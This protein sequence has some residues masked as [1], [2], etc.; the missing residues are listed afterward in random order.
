MNGTGMTGAFLY[1]IMYL[2]ISECSYAPKQLSLSG[3]A[4]STENEVADG[5]SWC[6]FN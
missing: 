6:V 3:L 4:M 2:R 1:I 5:M